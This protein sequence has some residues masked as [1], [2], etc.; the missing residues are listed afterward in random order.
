MRYI[1]KLK[2]VMKDERG[3]ALVIA[4]LMM[5][6]LTLLGFTSMMYSTIDLTVAG[7][8]RS[9]L[10]AQYA[11]E[12]GIS[13]GMAELNA[14]PSPIAAAGPYGA[15]DLD[16]DMSD[17][18]SGYTYNVHMQ[19]KADPDIDGTGV[20]LDGD[21]LTEVV[22]YNKEFYTTSTKAPDDGGYPVVVITSTATDNV[23]GSSSIIEV[24]LTKFTIPIATRIHGALTANGAVDLQGS[25]DIDG[26]NFEEDG[27]TP[28]SIG[29]KPGIDAQGD[30]TV[31][32][33]KEDQVSGSTGG[34]N[35]F[36]E[37][38]AGASDMLTSLG[39]ALGFDNTADADEFL[40]NESVV[41][42]FDYSAG[43]WPS[44]MDSSKVYYV[45]V[46]GGVNCNTEPNGTG[47]LIIHNPLF[48]PEVWYYSDMTSSGF[49]T[50]NPLY[51]ARLDQSVGN[52]AYDAAY[53]TS[54][55]PATLGNVNGNANFRGVI[56]ADEV[57]ALLGNISITG[58]IISLANVAAHADDLTGNCTVKYSSD[59][60]EKYAMAGGTQFNTK[61]SWKKKTAY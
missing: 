42:V 35:S 15:D 12:A 37:N 49:D 6:V 25:F 7:N 30:V 5:I 50:S 26:N 23:T 61:L 3:A 21:V 11:A 41:Q 8:E 58:A 20:G 57:N 34:S 32:A 33:S 56:I 2:V 51:D 38:G 40:E 4:M 31:Q 39:D 18:V 45:Q 48:N 47:L 10:A 44:P 14:D 59:A 43:E 29:A 17:S 52:A 55:G 9:S 13:R 28:S 27:T 46:S 19:Y 60:V 36:T 22:L 16:I 54:V 24:E 1:N 53:K